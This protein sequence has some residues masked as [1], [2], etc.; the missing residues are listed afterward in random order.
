MISFSN[1]SALFSGN[2]VITFDEFLEL[3]RDLD[4]QSN[5]SKK[6]DDVEEIPRPSS[7]ACT[8]SKVDWTPNRKK[9]SSLKCRFDFNGRSSSAEDTSNVTMNPLIVAFV[10]AG[11]KLS[12]ASKLQQSTDDE[13]AP[14]LHHPFSSAT[15][16]SNR[17][18]QRDSCW[19]QS[20]Q[21]LKDNLSIKTT[22]DREERLLTEFKLFDKVSTSS[23]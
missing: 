12:V 19:Y 22:R 3:M 14:L 9:S 21:R 16:N 2:G 10:A 6:E 7:A 13:Q 11:K 5:S 15:P 1:I 18:G 8:G 4:K 23:I 20:E 17:K